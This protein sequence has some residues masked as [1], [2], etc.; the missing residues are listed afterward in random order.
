MRFDR[1]LRRWPPAA[2]AGL[3]LS[4][5]IGGWLVDPY[6]FTDPPVVTAVPIF[7]TAVHN[8]RI[9]VILAAGGL[10]LGLPTLLTALWNGFQA[11]ALFA[12]V[13]PPMW[14]PLLVHGVPE[15][16]GQFS[17][18]VAGLELAREVVARVAYD[19][20]LVLR[21]VA[22]WTLAAIVLTGIAAVLE[23]LVSPA[24]AGVRGL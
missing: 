20:S 24:V 16:A 17:A 13:S 5:A 22:R 10:F 23:S 11:G 18:T 6:S 9:I 1:V 4:A 2:A 7:G 3:F 19:R 14:L 8:L 15:L 21:V 12:A